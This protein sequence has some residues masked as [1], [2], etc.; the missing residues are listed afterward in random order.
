M[1]RLFFILWSVCQEP[2]LGLLHFADWAGC[3]SKDTRGYT[4][5]MRDQYLT[6]AAELHARARNESDE[7]ARREYENLARQFLRLADQANRNAFVDPIYEPT[8]PKIKRQS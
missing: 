5:S 4:M 3:T 1:Q 7:M 6:R 8:P 2:F